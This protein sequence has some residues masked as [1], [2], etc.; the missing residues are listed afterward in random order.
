MAISTTH[1][2]FVHKEF[3]KESFN[4][5]E[6]AQEVE[7]NML[8]F[9]RS[10]EHSKSLNDVK[11]RAIII[12]S[13]GMMTGGRI[14][15]HLYHRLQRKE[16][17]VLIAGYQAEGTRGRRLLDG[18]KTIRMFGEDVPVQCKVEYISSMSGHADKEE[19]FKWMSGF[20]N[21]PK[22]TFTV[23]GELPDLDIYAEEIRKRFGWNVTVP[24][25][26]ESVDLF[27]GI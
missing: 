19:L 23:H 26:L 4:P 2:F 10:S 20:K 6:F 18:E 16:D 24:Q 7:T 22:V 15:H 17:T 21:K 11:K 27:T 5:K 12:S 9:V 3:L 13:S 14:L 1:L 25:Y 8:I